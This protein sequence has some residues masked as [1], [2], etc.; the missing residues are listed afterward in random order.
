MKEKDNQISLDSF[1]CHAVSGCLKKFFRDLP[2]PLFT[3][4]AHDAFLS[5]TSTTLFIS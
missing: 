1:D 2:D 3:Y 4:E 5:A